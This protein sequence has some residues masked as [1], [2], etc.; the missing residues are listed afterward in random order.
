MSRSQ[1]T[2]LLAAYGE[3]DSASA[4]LI[5]DDV[6]AVRVAVAWPTVGST[7]SRPEGGRPPIGDRERWLWLW[8]GVKYD[9]DEL[10]RATALPIAAIEK[11][12]QLLITA[13]LIRPDG[14]TTELALAVARRRAAGELK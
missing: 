13:R 1:I 2:K 3:P 6:H 11:R 12:M 10:A 14:T 5:A 8:R 7:W 4:V 9:A